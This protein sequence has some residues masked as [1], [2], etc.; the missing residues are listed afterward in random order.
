MHAFF[1]PWT[2]D[3]DEVLS[4]FRSAY[5]MQNSIYLLIVHQGHYQLDGDGGHSVHD[6]NRQVEEYCAPLFYVG[7]SHWGP[8]IF[9]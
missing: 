3:V 8:D 7:R 4:P 9:Y 6:D 1:L 5:V 2:R